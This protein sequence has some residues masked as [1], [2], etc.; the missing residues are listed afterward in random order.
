MD[1]PL[2]ASKLKSGPKNLWPTTAPDCGVAL[3]LDTS[4]SPSSSVAIQFNPLRVNSIQFGADCQSLT[5]CDPLPAV[6]LDEDPGARRKRKGTGRLAIRRIE[7]RKVGEFL[8][9]VD[10]LQHSAFKF[11]KLFIIIHSHFIQSL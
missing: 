11:N 2:K 5:G 6:V 7:F 1:I 9:K 10:L 8:V 4:E 3:A